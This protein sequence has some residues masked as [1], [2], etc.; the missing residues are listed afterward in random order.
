MRIVARCSASCVNGAKETEVLHTKRTGSGHVQRND[1]RK[2][3]GPRTGWATLLATPHSKV[4]FEVHSRKR[5]FHCE[6]RHSAVIHTHPS[7]DTSVQPSVLMYFAFGFF[8]LITVIKAGWLELFSSWAHKPHTSLPAPGS[9]FSSS[10]QTAQRLL[11]TADCSL[12]L[13]FPFP[14][15][16]NSVQFICT[17][18]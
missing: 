17:T 8:Y 16:R 2:I 7:P 12:L 9:V 10:R 14:T 13:I 18:A 3:K 1:D 11:T 6:P 15:T 5:G 4:W